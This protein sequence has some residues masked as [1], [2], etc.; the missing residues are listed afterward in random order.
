MPVPRTV[1]ASMRII[2]PVEPAGPGGTAEMLEVNVTDWPKVE[3]LRAE[4]TAVKLLARLTVWVGREP[5]LPVKAVSPVYT[6]VILCTP[7]PSVEVIIVAIPPLNVAGAARLF[8][9]SLNCT[10]PVGVPEPPA[11]VTFAVKVTG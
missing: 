8:P 1:L 6:A 11:G 5:M 9:P 2:V 3:G 10:E 7:V 4:A